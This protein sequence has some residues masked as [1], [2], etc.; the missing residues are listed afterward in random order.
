MV[1]AFNEMKRSLS[2]HI[3]QLEEK[4]RLEEEINRQ[5]VVLLEQG[6]LLRESQLYALQSQIN[7]H[8]L[9]NTLNVIARTARN[10][11]PR[12]TIELIQAT[13]EILRFSLKNLHRLVPLREELGSAQAYVFI[14][15]RRFA[16]ELDISMEVDD[17]VPRDILVPPMIIQPLIENSIQHGLTGKLFNRT[18]WGRV[19]RNDKH[20][21]RIAIEDNGAGMPSDLVEEFNS[22]SSISDP[23][24]KAEKVGLRSVVRRIALAFGD[25]GCVRIESEPGVFTRVTLTVPEPTPHRKDPGNV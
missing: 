5:S 2:T 10:G 22:L 17:D 4:H 13:S 20:Q 18:V 23:L 6:K 16:G 15:Q 8:F 19:S 7:P 11:K 24:I 14:Q 3:S 9:F 1:T 21:V 25:D 12:E